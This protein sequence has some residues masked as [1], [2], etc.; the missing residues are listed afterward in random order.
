GPGV[1]PGTIA[2]SAGWGAPWSAEDDRAAA[3][4]E[5]AALRV[6]ADGAGQGAALD[7]LADAHQVLHRAGV[8]DTLDVLLDDRPLVEVACDVVR[9]G[10][11]DLHAAV[12]GL[13]VGACALERGQ[14][15]VVDVDDL[16][17]EVAAE[18]VGQDLHVPREHHQLGAGV[19][20]QV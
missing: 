11:D 16:P 18:L 13:T 9:R 7:V 3:V 10:A 1:D 12:V 19:G 15:R 17:A 6:P 20:D 4:Q 8:A 5:H 2:W 14:E